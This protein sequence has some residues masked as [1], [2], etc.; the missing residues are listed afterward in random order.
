MYLEL[1]K[2]YV[3]YYYKSEFKVL[4]SGVAI[5]ILSG[6]YERFVKEGDIEPIEKDEDNQ[7]YFD[8]GDLYKT[9]K[10][11][12]LR[13]AKAAYALKKISVID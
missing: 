12:K 5:Y 2:L 11:D 1:L 9:E 13:V 8:A 4:C 10:Y 7:R 6:L 3:E